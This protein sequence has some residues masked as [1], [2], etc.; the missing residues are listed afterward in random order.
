[1]G[2]SAKELRREEERVHRAIIDALE[3]LYPAGITFHIPNQRA[4]QVMRFILHKLGVRPGMPDIGVL[5][6]HGRIGWIE[7]KDPVI[8]RLT[9]SQKDLHPKMNALGHTVHVVDDVAHIQPITQK[10]RE[11]DRHG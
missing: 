4:S 10:W 1:M 6:P 11:E 5:R 8:G 2:F 9:K 7:V 3:F